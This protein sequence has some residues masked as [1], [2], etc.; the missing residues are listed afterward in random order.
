MAMAIIGVPET[1]VPLSGVGMM[2]TMIVIV[3]VLVV[4]LAGVLRSQS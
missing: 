2:L 3:A 1:A 4:Q